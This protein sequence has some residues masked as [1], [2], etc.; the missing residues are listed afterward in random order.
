MVFH[1]LME[2]QWMPRDEYNTC[3]LAFGIVRAIEG[4]RD[5]KRN[6]VSQLFAPV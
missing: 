3:S 2:S 5:Q 4:E 1:M 6:D